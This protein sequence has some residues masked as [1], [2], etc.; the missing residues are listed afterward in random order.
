[1]PHSPFSVKDFFSNSFPGPFAAV[2]F[3]ALQRG[4]S[5]YMHQLILPVNWFFRFFKKTLKEKFDEFNVTDNEE[6]DIC[7][8]IIKVS[9]TPKESK[10]GK[11]E[12]PKS[13]VKTTFSLLRL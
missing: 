13:P 5:S 9:N 2:L 6:K 3:C 8:N 12:L 10:R 7:S 11:S 1:M 4:A